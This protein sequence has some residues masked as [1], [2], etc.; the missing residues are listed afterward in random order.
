M[1]RYVKRMHDKTSRGAAFGRLLLT[2]L[3]CCFAAV[4]EN[5]YAQTV[6]PP[7]G[8]INTVAGPGTPPNLGDGGPAT[9]AELSTPFAT[10]VDAVGN[11]YIADYGACRIRKVTVS[12]GVISTVAGDGTC[13]FLGNGGQA[14]STAISY[15][16]GVA[17][18]SAGNIYIADRTSEEIRKVTAS[19]G[20]I[21]SVAGNEDQGYSGD[22]GAA[23]SAELNL[24]NG[25][26]L[27][28]AGNI[29]IVDNGNNRIRKVTVST[30]II[31]TV[32]GN[33]TAGYSGD[34]GAAINAKLDNPSGVAVDGAGN[35]YIADYDN[36]VIRKVTASTGIISTLA[37]DGAVGYVGD[38]GPATSAELYWPTG[39]AVDT[40]GN[41]YIADQDNYVIRKVTAST[42]IIT[43]IAGNGTAAYP[44]DG[45]PATSAELSLPQGVAVDTAGNIYIADTFNDRIRVVGSAL[46]TINTVAGNGTEGYSGDGGAAISAELHL[47]LGVAVDSAGNIYIA[48]YGNNRIRE[49]TLSTGIISTVAGNGTA[50][51]SGDGGAATSAELY[52]APGVAVD[53]AGNIYIAD[54]DNNRIRKVTVSTGIISTVA[55]NGTAGYSG[56]GGAAINAEL[57]NPSGVAVDGAGNIY[58][59][60][61]YNHRIRKVT[62]STGIIS[63]VA[64][65]GTAGYSGD[66]G[67]AIN[68]KLYFPYG[69][70]VDGAGNICIADSANNRIREV[71]AS[72]GIISTVAG[73]GTASYS[74]DG[75]AATSAELRLPSAVAVDGAGNIYI[76][77]REN[78]R[79]REV[80]ASTGIISTVAGNGT[81]GYSGDGGAATSAELHFP[82]GVAVGGAGNIYI[83]DYGNNR[84][85][86]VSFPFSIQYLSP[87][88]GLVGTSVTIVGSLF[89]TTQG[90]STVTFNGTEATSIAN[91]GP[92]GITAKV[93][94]GATTGD[95][96][97]TEKGAAS[98]GVL[99]TVAA[100]PNITSLSTTSGPPGTLVTITGTNFGQS[101]GTSAVLF[102]GVVA[103]PT[104]WTNGTTIEVPVPANAST[105][106]VVVIVDGVQSN[107]VV[108]TDTSAPIITSISPT[109]GTGGTS[110]TLMGSL[111]GSSQ[112]TSTVTFNGQ[113]ATPT[114]W[115][116]S[117]NEIVVPAPSGVTTGNVVVTVNGIPSNG[118]QFVAKPT[119]AS[120]SPTAGGVGTAVTITGANFGS[121]P[122]TVTFNGVAGTPAYWSSGRI[123]VPV[124]T[125]ATT[126]TV[127]VTVGGNASNGASFTVNSSPG[128]S[129][130]SPSSGT[131]GTVVMIAGSGFGSSQGSST[132]SFNGHLAGA[133]QLWKANEI[134]A[135][136]PA[137]G[138]GGSVTVTVNGLVSNP[139]Q[140]L[141]VPGAPQITSLSLTQG[142]PLMGF[143]IT[144]TNF[145]PN[146][147]NTVS[148][149]GAQVPILTTTTSGNNILITVQVPAGAPGGI[150]EVI[151][152]VGPG[153]EYVSSNAVN[154]N[155]IQ[156]FGCAL[157]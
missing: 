54:Y 83:A 40:A 43:T 70:A 61:Y 151:V 92:N 100:V 128:I 103:T 115:M 25:V 135:T 157:P 116:N 124:P 49:G 127:V 105:G 102:N 88:A 63:T 23:T 132:V 117:G 129:S 153:P 52:D 101:Q 69:V 90:T 56:D 60:D 48:D 134:Q 104:I 94:A 140:F 29:Y 39:V 30:G 76:A 57:D 55:G 142:P 10:A 31:S 125:G 136:V 121:A 126:G 80:T 41:I 6:I 154:F 19:T 36:D 79:I 18:D 71:T 144:G 72:T 97:V 59:A 77:D 32:A 150:A 145:D 68:A 118:I 99:F 155:V 95:V 73:N 17:V 152:N 67:A 91:W 86:A 89:G 9:S 143:V 24:P 21:S 64:G 14:T 33:G 22:G 4:T 130:I 38:G 78:E 26:A 107:G 58:I 139:L 45:G 2:G 37:G 53:G 96:V 111:F 15:P 27:D 50:G 141:A 98:N 28:T 51:Y 106:P 82:Y 85:R 20:I 47:P 138:V 3:L 149:G 122:G 65:N 112:G 35:I 74:G 62:L 13:G 156:A 120:L 110:V 109:S 84:I 46:P 93:P 131:V 146:G 123:V 87:S 11:I 5:A 113:A 66:G 8:I 7:M 16:V 147:N 42:G 75:G 34:G 108:F 148:I 119:I 137:G 44:G 1:I 81:A 12:T 114:A 133:A